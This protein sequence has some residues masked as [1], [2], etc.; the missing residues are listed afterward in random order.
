LGPVEIV[1]GEA[2]NAP[3]GRVEEKKGRGRTKQKQAR[4]ERYW[5]LIRALAEMALDLSNGKQ[6]SQ[7]PRAGLTS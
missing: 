1:K 4:L 6:V 5:H 7:G 3:Q 2:E